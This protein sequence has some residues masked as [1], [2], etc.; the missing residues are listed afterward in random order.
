[1]VVVVVGGGGGNVVVV[2]PGSVVVDVG[3]D[4]VDVGDVATV[5]GVGVH[6]GLGRFF[7]V[8]VVV[9]WCTGRFGFGRLVETVSV[10][11]AW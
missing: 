4:V 9:G 7:T 2:S 8:V 3:S 11:V 6:V 5:V 1:M 10:M